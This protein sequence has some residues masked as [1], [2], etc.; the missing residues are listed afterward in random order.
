[1]SKRERERGGG[2][3]GC[4]STMRKEEE[5]SSVVVYCCQSCRKPLFSEN[6]I[7]LA[8]L[9]DKGAQRRFAGKGVADNDRRRTDC[10]SF[11]LNDMPKWLHEEVTA[12]L[13]ERPRVEGKLIC[14]C[15]TKFG[16]FD[17]AGS[18]CSCGAWV[19]PGIQVP[20]SRVDARIAQLE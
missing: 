8:H 7:S 17:W 13:D 19:T 11:F 16:S 14:T 6:A 5:V 3:K 20:K 10:T 1:V 18:Q 9:D 12:P 2:G 4:C 15:G